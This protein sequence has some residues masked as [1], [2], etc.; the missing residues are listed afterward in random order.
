MYINN[1]NGHIHFQWHSN[2][3]QFKDGLIVWAADERAV[4]VRLNPQT[5]GRTKENV[6]IEKENE[7]ATLW[8]CES[9][10]QTINNGLCEFGR[11]LDNKP[12]TDGCL[13]DAYVSGQVHQVGNGSNGNYSIINWP[14]SLFL[15]SLFWCFLLVC[16]ARISV[17][18]F[19]V[20]F[21]YTS[22]NELGPASSC[23]YERARHLGL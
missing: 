3:L 17:I 7:A 10:S 4:T 15:F 11:H 12:V 16:F 19:S 21:L 1:R 22:I 6:Y 8:L 14:F 5:H 13:H 20:H 23:N 18:Y 9:A 2:C